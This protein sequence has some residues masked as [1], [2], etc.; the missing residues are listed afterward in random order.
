MNFAVV[1]VGG[2]VAPRHLKAIKATGNKLVAAHDP[3]DSVGILDQYSFDVRFF[4]E[5]ERFDRYLDK[6]R[7]LGESERIHYFS[8]CSP[9]YLHDA[10]CRMALRNGANVICEKPIVIN[11][12]N[13][14]TLEQLEQET[15][16]TINTVLQL[17]LHPEL[18]ALRE[19]LTQNLINS[20]HNVTLTYI[21]A[22]G[23]WYH[24]SWKGQEEK[25]GGIGINIGVHL[26]DLILWLFG[27][28]KESYVFHRDA[29]R[30]AG[31]LELEH[32]SVRWYLSIAPNDLPF[33]GQAGNR[34]S[35]R[36]IEI[37]GEEFEFSDGFGDLHTRIYEQ[38]LVGN[39]FRIRDVRAVTELTHIIRT[40]KIAP[41]DEFEHP[42]LRRLDNHA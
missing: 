28:V 2:Y 31:H 40:A 7:R 32:A 33:E 38:A 39:G 10:H 12:W 20:R 19:R 11:P 16:L 4:S 23:G 8:I 3:N 14:D 5:I 6:L 22:R 1:G 35:Y 34:T 36:C 25:S 41:M 18:L 30:L 37:D 27:S 9:N 24:I 13:L 26:F 15:G 21:T 29:E 42:M 17:R